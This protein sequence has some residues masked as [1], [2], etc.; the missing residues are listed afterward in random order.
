MKV[1]Q[2]LADLSEDLKAISIDDW[3]SYKYMFSKVKSIAADFIKKSNDGSKL[4]F[5]SPEAFTEVV[6]IPMILVNITECDLGTNLCSKL[7]RS[8]FKIPEIHSGKFGAIIK[9]VASL[10]FGQIYVDCYSPQQWKN[11]QKREFKSN[12]IKYFY[13]LNG[14]IYIPIANASERSPENIRIEALFKDKFEVYKFQQQI[15]GCDECEQNLES[16]KKPLD[17]EVVIP[18]GL[19]DDIKKE[20][21][22]QMAGVY[23]KITPDTY[24]NISS[25]DK[26]NERDLNNKKKKG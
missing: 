1:K 25:N 7:M 13:F 26:T 9:Q 8:K 5:K 16:C 17:F 11:I 21:I 23:L 15:V 18:Y 3:I 2:F 19:E 22:N 20:F 6:G 10:T 24:P 14:F 12:E 4:L